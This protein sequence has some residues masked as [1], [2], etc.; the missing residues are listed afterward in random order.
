M[1]HHGYQRAV[2]A[3]RHEILVIASSLIARTTT[4][5]EFGLDYLIAVTP[6][7][8]SGAAHDSGAARSKL[9]F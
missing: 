7:T 3:A 4:Y 8:L 2:E 5:Q 1:R 6:K 9:T